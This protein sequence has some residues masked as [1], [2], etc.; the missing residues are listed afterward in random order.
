MTIIYFILILGLIIF[1]HELGHFIFAKKARVYVYEFAIGMGPKII[2]KKSKKSE[3]I[4]SLR[5]IPLGGF[6]AMA[7]EDLEDKDV[8]PEKNLNNKTWIQRFMVLFAGPMMNFILAFV[9][10]F[11]Y[12]LIFGSYETKPI[13]GKV[14]K[15]G[16]AYV[17]GLQSGDKILK[18]NNKKVGSWDSAITELQFINKDQVTFNVERNN[19]SMNIIIRPEKK[20]DKN[21]NVTYY[22]GIAQNNEKKYG[23]IASAK[24]S[25][26]KLASL[27]HS[28]TTII[29][30]LF[31]GKVGLS[32]MSGPVGIYEVVGQQ[33]KAG[34]SNLIYLTA[35]LSINVGYMN[36][37][38]FP[39]FD[40]GRILFLIIE[41]IR[42]KKVTPKIEATIN[43]VGF[44]LLI[45]L[46]LFITGNDIIRI[47]K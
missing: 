2:S 4:Y 28:M 22:Y 1:I 44:A 45:I 3:T 21:D 15:D 41:A 34:I 39:A 24:F 20:T 27:T 29:K 33:A 36:L 7:G 6:C 13:V 17:A 8:P 35:Y 40:G 14:A 47:I 42:R 18:I 11:M 31:T 23:L 46:M 10:L 38:P 30:G 37:I 16:P 43:N 25:L 26:N 19:K 12:A 5:L 32:S 9:L